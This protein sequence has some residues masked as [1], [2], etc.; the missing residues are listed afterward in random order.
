MINSIKNNIKK[1]FNYYGWKLTKIYRNKNYTNSKPNLKL[2]EAMHASK[3]ILHMGAHRGTESAVYD[4]FHKKTLWI[5]AN[6][7]IYTDLKNNINIYINQKA[8]NI[9]LHEFDNEVF[10]FNISNNDGASSSIYN[11]GAESLKDNLEMVETIKLKSK[12]IDTFF[13]QESIQAKDYDFWVMDIQGAELPVLK[14]AQK[15]LESCNFIYVEVSSGDFYKNGTQWSELKNFLKKK[16]F[17]NQWEPQDKH[18]DI[19]F[20]KNN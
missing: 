17:E 7:K 9:L 14:G 5:E 19:L 12:K 15:S 1:M 16:N 4:W 2:L 13:L 11:F 8:Y 18:K 10:S 6:P 20:K 3:G